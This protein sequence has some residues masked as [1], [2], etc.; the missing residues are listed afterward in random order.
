MAPSRSV[1][2]GVP[3]TGPDWLVERF[4]E[5][6][7]CLRA[8][9]YGGPRRYGRADDTVHQPAPQS[10]TTPA[11]SNRYEPGLRQPSVVRSQHAPRRGTAAERSSSSTRV[12]QSP[13]W[14]VSSIQPKRCFW[15]RVG[16]RAR[17]SLRVGRGSAGAAGASVGRAR[18]FKRRLNRRSSRTA[19]AHENTLSA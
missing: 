9:A 5:H 10:H 12:T 8:V 18:S 19:L 3:I 11:R 15:T 1:T 7:G 4:A 6:G 16:S 17:L 13:G 14:S 2:S